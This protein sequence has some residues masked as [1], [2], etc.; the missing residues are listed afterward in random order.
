MEKTRYD[1][2]DIAKGFGIILMVFGHIVECKLVYNWI[3]SF[4]M[5]LFF[6]LSGY[7]FNTDKNAKDFI[8]SKAKTLLIPYY[9]CGFITIAFNT[10][11][12]YMMSP[13]M[14]T[15]EYINDVWMEIPHIP[16]EALWF[17]GCMFIMQIV[18][19]FIVKY[20]RN[21]YVVLLVS[22]I[23]T[24][25]GV[26]LNKIYGKVMLNIDS[27]M[28]MS[29]FFGI[30]YFM[31]KRD[32]IIVKTLENTWI[33]NIVFI[34]STALSASFICMMMSHGLQTMNVYE[35]WY[36]NPILT[37]PCAIVGIISVVSLS[38][39]CDNDYI[40]YIGKNSLCYYAFNSI[41]VFV[42]RFVALAIGL[43]CGNYAIQFMFEILTTS[44]ALHS[45]TILD[46]RLMQ[47]KL[48]FIIG[49]F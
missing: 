38:N 46:K 43:I 26:A 37:Y 19:Y 3:S 6:F 44:V 41:F 1:W 47:S 17:L 40:K 24:V 31:K 10:L 27:A 14:T 12:T 34:V 7:V 5:P 30:G 21:D 32:R 8:I 15:Q 22:F 28:T 25:F 9:I 49:K 39:I 13:G 11:F 23:I 36:G 29:L 35:R 20:L 4:H 48:K 33:S 18:F 45:L 16:S 42:C 2:V